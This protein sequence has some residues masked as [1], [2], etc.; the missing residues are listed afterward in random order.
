[1]KNKLLALLSFLPL[2]SGW[3]NTL[4]LLN[5]SPYSLKAVIYDANGILLSEVTLDRGNTMQWSDNVDQFDTATIPTPSSASP[6][7]VNWYCMGGASYG[8]CTDIPPGA[9]VNSQS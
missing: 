8:I 6:Y 3:T 5:D 7:V 9:M 2:A 4:T 1:M